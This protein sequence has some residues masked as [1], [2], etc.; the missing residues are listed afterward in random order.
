MHKRLEVYIAYTYV[1]L[2][3]LLDRR[4]VAVGGGGKLSETK[5]RRR[6]GELKRGREDW[7]TTTS[8]I[9]SIELV[10]GSARVDV[11]T[12]VPCTAGRQLGY[13]CRCGRWHQR[14]VAVHDL[15]HTRTRK[16]KVQLWLVT[17]KRWNAI[18]A[19][20][21]SKIFVPKTIQIWL[22]SP[23]CHGCFWSFLSIQRLFRV[24]RFPHVM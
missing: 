10:E 9:S 12:R 18:T 24:F 14:A 2:F 23:K 8:V 20:V 15:H 22:I 1:R 5:R 6:R 21:V 19:P 17:G 3:R 7:S 16:Q 4:R 11:D 13:R